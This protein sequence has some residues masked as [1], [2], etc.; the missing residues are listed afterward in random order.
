[1]SGK[2]NTAALGPGV[3]LLQEEGVG[4]QPVAEEESKGTAVLLAHNR[5]VLTTARAMRVKG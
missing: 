2:G 5:E 3:H 4:C 1:M